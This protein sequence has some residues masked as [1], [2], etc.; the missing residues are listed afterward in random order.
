VFLVKK[1]GTVDFRKIKNLG[2]RA[3]D[4]VI[5]ALNANAWCQFGSSSTKLSR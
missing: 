5:A 3:N 4:L 1:D 2:G